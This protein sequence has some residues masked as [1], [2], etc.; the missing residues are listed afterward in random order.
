MGGAH[1][2][3]QYAVEPGALGAH[4]VRTQELGLR[5]R[6]ALAVRGLLAVV[7][8]VRDARRCGTHT[9]YVLLY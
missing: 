2:Q 9:K 7:A 8:R 3:G 5:A 4:A 1:Q 6:E